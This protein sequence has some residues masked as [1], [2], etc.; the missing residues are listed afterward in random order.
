MVSYF[1][2]ELDTTPPT[3]EIFTPNSASHKY[4]T[5]VRIES[6]EELLEYQNIY[7]INSLGYRQEL[8]FIYHYFYYEGEII[9][10]N[11]NEI[12]TVFA[13]LKDTVGNI[14]ELVS[15]PVRVLDGQPLVIELSSNPRQTKS[16]VSSQN[17][18]LEDNERKTSEG[19]FQSNHIVHDTERELKTSP[20]NY[21]PLSP[22]YERIKDRR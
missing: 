15:K 21:I 8:H 12:V 19:I 5:T 2:L 7:A 9:F 11:E 1:E 3:I 18:K 17:F 22:F 10:E 13:Q 20:K 4:S 16:S 14:S 6:N